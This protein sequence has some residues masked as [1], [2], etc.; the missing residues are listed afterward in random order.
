MCWQQ[1]GTGFFTAGLNF[2]GTNTDSTYS[3]TLGDIDGDGDL[4]VV[5]ANRD[6]AGQVWKNNGDGTFT[7]TGQALAAGTGAEL[8]DLDGDGDLDLFFARGF[9]SNAP[10]EVWL[11]DGSGTFTDSG[12]SLGND[13]GRFVKLGDI[14]GDGDL[15]A[16]TSNG[17]ATNTIRVWLN[18]GSAVFTDSGQAIN[19]AG[20]NHWGLALGDLD[21]DGDLDLF[22]TT[23]LGNDAVFLNDGSGSFSLHQTVTITNGNSLRLSLGD[24]DGDGDLDA[25][26]SQRNGNTKLL[27]NDGTGIFTLGQDLNDGIISN[28]SADFG[29]FDNDGDLD[30]LLS[31]ES[32]QPNTLWLNDGNG[33]FTDSGQRLGSGNTLEVGIGDLDGDGDLDYVSANYAQANRVWLN[34]VTLPYTQDFD[35]ENALGMVLNTPGNFSFVDDGGNGLLQAD[36]SGF[37]G[38]SIAVLQFDS[39]PSAVDIAADITAVSGPNRDNNGFLIFDYISDNDFKYAGLAEGANE[40]IIGHYQGDFSNRLA[41]VD[42]DDQTRVINPDQAY[43]LELYLNEEFVELT[44]DGEKIAYVQFAAPVTGGRVGIASKDAVARFD[45]FSVAEAATRTTDLSITKTSS[46]V[47]VEQGAPLSYTVTVSNNGAEYVS[48]VTVADDYSTI[49]DNVTWTAVVAERRCRHVVG[50]WEP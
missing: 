13:I 25:A 45:D 50:L 41:T 32:G 19:I 7:N 24:V 22:A 30:L 34:E 33:N 17:S 8:G 4:D 46:V 28:W 21:G 31:K 35:Y 36:N 14:D 42:W 39:L 20:S 26:V 23:Y 38:L 11:N 37:S 47:A 29:D 6:T 9:T 5:F 3:S 2:T 18:N 10:D 49:L 16:L 1:R 43:H 15:D 27:L 12:Q 40:W 48:G 44:V